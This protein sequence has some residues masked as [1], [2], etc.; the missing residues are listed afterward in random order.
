MTRTGLA[1]PIHL[2]RDGVVISGIDD[3]SD[4]LRTWLKRRIDRSV[5]GDGQ[6]PPDPVVEAPDPAPVEDVDEV[7][8]GDE[9][10]QTEMS[11]STDVDPDAPGRRPRSLERTTQTQSPAGMARLRDRLGLPPIP[12]RP[13][14]SEVLAAAPPPRRVDRA[15]PESG[16][17][18][19]KVVGDRT[20]APSAPLPSSPHPSSANPSRPP[21]P[22]R[23]RA[24]LPKRP[25]EDQ[26]S[27]GAFGPSGPLPLATGPAVRPPAS[28][29]KPRRNRID[30][31][32]EEDD[33]DEAQ[34]VL[35]S[36][37]TQE[38][39][40]WPAEPE[41]IRS[42]GAM[43]RRE[44]VDDPDTVRHPHMPVSFINP[45]VMDDETVLDPASSSQRWRDDHVYQPPPPHIEPSVSPVPARRPPKAPPSARPTQRLPEGLDD[46][47]EWVPL[48]SEDSDPQPSGEPSPSASAPFGRSASLPPAPRSIPEP[49]RAS[50]V[51]PV[52]GPPPLPDGVRTQDVRTIRLP[53]PPPSMPPGPPAGAR[54]PS[55]PSG[56]PPA[57]SIP[58]Q[59]APS[60]GSSAPAG[61]VDL[62]AQTT[63]G[64][65]PP[66]SPSAP[67]Q[68]QRRQIAL[69]G[70][71][72][73]LAVAMGFFVLALGMLL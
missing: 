65:P 5:E 72:L 9:V 29:P 7:D 18:I 46:A 23:S 31:W 22:A 15:A 44:T 33:E 56:P 52:S 45:A 42:W 48:F 3:P 35:A 37:W 73:F 70:V 16:P 8:D 4:P 57:R 49:V 1:F 43:M 58:P 55:P 27:S 63:V 67:P 40:D 61:R 39:I 60:S 13:Q 36:P 68:N 21:A 38:A 51:G 69:V 11:R 24:A 17:V 64:H 19:P 66:E 41:T 2:A 54:R 62:A 10:D 34:T 50:P 14:A 71:M 6:A 12:G 30:P 47:D 25:V 28:E 26:P 32:A 59:A 53:D 20:P